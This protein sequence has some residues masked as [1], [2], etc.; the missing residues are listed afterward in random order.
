MYSVMLMA[1]MTVSAPDSPQ[2]LREHCGCGG[3]ADERAGAIGVQIPTAK[4]PGIDQVDIIA[5][6]ERRDRAG[7]PPVRQTLRV[8]AD[9]R[10][11]VD[12]RS[13][14]SFRLDLSPGPYTIRL[15]VRSAVADRSG[16]G[17]ARR[18]RA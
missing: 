6:A 15:V 13:E 11:S 18:R 8:P 5:T 10:S 3:F 2:W 4:T 16:G 1:A 7:E 17:V 12:G 14:A 9:A